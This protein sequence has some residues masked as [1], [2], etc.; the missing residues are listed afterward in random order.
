[1]RRS[2]AAGSEDLDPPH[3]RQGS[4]ATHPFS[5]G[6]APPPREIRGCGC[7]TAVQDRRAP[8]VGPCDRGELGAA[9]GE[10]SDPEPSRVLV[11]GGGEAGQGA[12]GKCW[13][14]LREKYCWLI[15]DGWFVVREK[16]C[17]LMA[18]KPNEQG[19]VCRCH[20]DL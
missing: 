10:L 15:A 12:S 19:R 20:E 3:E 18:D 9:R 17:W 13:F 6:R 7:S 11:V 16:Y 4:P 1:V 5:L 14:V 8:P 2:T